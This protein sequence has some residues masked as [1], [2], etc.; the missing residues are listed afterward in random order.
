MKRQSIVLLGA[1]VGLGFAG[2]V[3][4]D[5]MSGMKMDSPAPTTQ[6]TTRP[7]QAVDLRNTLCPVSGDKVEDS[8][9]VEI[10]DGKVYHLCCSDCHTDF[11]KDPAKYAAAVT[12]NPGKFGVK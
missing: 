12:A 4:A 2:W 11:E 10:Y 8:K 1:I 3:A 5:D 7:F 9:L 6:P